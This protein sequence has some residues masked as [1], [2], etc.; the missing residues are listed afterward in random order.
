MIRKHVFRNRGLAAWASG[1]S[2]FSGGCDVASG[3]LGGVAL[4]LEIIASAL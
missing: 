4:L 3:V 2:L 1:G